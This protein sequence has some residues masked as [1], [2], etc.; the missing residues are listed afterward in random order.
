LA[1]YRIRVARYDEEKKKYIDIGSVRVDVD[2]PVDTVISYVS[3]IA[4]I[5]ETLAKEGER[6]KAVFGVEA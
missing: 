5:V 4:R 1:R 2:L 3:T 6:I